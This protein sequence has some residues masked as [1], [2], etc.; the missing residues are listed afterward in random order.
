MTGIDEFHREVSSKGYESMRPGIESTPYDA[1]CVE[2]I[3]P[4]GNRIRFNESLM[5]ASAT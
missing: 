1:R 3:G 5:L 2:V 4:F